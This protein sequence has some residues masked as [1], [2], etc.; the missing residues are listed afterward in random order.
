MYW[1]IGWG[2]YAH[3]LINEYAVYTLSSPLL[4][5]YKQHIDYLKKHAIDPDKRRYMSA[6]EAVRHYIDMDEYTLDSSFVLSGNLAEDWGSFSSVYGITTLGDTLRIRS[7]GT[8]EEKLSDEIFS[9]DSVVYTQ[10]FYDELLPHYYREEDP[11]QC[12]PSDS[13]SPFQSFVWIDSFS[14]HGLLPYHLLYLKRSLTQAFRDKDVK[15]ILRLS[16]DVGHYMGDAHVP[17]H[18]HSNYNGQKSGQLGIHAFWESQIPERYALS[19]FDLWGGQAKYI[20]DFPTFIWKVIEDTHEQVERVF[21]ADKYCRS[22]LNPAHQYEVVLHQNRPRQEPSKEFTTCFYEQL[23][24]M[25]DR[26]MRLAIHHLGC[27]WYSAWVD[28]GQ[29]DLNSLQDGFRID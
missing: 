27:F 9:L 1:T 2:F 16:S 25:V 10:W 15:K 21:T 5:F 7:F 6:F 28:A 8:G 20:E 4:G 23:E 22:Y 18:T 14:M 3:R 13:I 24:G 11:I 26:Q 12:W 19:S 29:P 17:L